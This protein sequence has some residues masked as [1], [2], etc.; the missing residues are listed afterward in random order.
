[1][2]RTERA[3]LR[4][5]FEAGVAAVEPGRLV[6]EALSLSGD[7]LSVRGGGAPLDLDLSDFDR[8]L[9]IG[10]GKA[11]GRM[12]AAAEEILGDRISGGAIAVKFPEE[13][14]TLRRIRVKVGGHPVPDAG[15]VDAAEAI[16][17]RA[18]SADAR[19][20]V[21]HLV[22]GGGSALLAA[23][24]RDETGAGTS[25]ADKRET[26]RLLLGCGAAIGEI[27]CV[28]KH[29]SG[30]KGG[31]LAG[32]LAPATVISLILSDV[33]G[34]RL[35]VISSGP[36]VPDPTTFSDA[37]EILDRYGIRDRIPESARTVLARGLAGEIPETPR[38]ADSAFQ[39]VHNRVIGT[40]FRALTAAKERAEELG[41]ATMIL[42]SRV[43]GEAREAAKFLWGVA[44]DA[45]TRSVP[46]SPPCC[47]LAGGETTVTLRGHGKGGRNQETALAFLAEMAREPGIARSIH[48]LGAATDGDD[49][50]TDA[51]GAFADA[52]AVDR[53]KTADLSIADHLRRNDAYPFFRA[54]DALFQPGPTGTNV[55]DL[56]ILLV[57]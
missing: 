57:R 40:N 30:I 32:W 15:S 21:L 38:P 24:W 27:N 13:G 7:R 47:I 26:T 42:T 16:S 31:R 28:R 25:L 49:G 20:L 43:T 1:M 10:A 33:V 34:D 12:A 41:Y 5:I 54:I 18:R 36:T 52:E 55:C 53:A 17:E 39:R 11:T 3:V 6:A 29:L 19:T 46:L 8:I 4:E 51:A 35:D 56:T 45:A 48:F 22:S 23:P 2:R 9:V 37:A 44:A 14:K 50:P